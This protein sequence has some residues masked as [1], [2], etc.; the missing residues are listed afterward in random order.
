VGCMRRRPTPAHQAQSQLQ[1]GCVLAEA[2]LRPAAVQASAGQALD[3]V[4][5]MWGLPIALEVKRPEALGGI[6]SNVSSGLRQCRGIAPLYALALDLTDCVG[7]P[8]AIF[9]GSGAQ[10]LEEAKRRFREANEQASD[11]IHGRKGD[12]D[13][14]RCG[15]LWTFAGATF[16]PSDE[17]RRPVSKLMVAGTAFHH[18]ASGLLLDQSRRLSESILG[19]FRELGASI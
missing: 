4:V 14:D 5:E 3:Y 17:P 15:V 13:F 10:A 19:G 9:Q 12:A 11:Y 1:F 16:W 18:A 2:G 8:S 6:H 7:L